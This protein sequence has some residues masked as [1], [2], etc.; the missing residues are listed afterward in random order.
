E[1]LQDDIFAR[2]LTFPN[3]L[4]T[5]HQAFFTR[6]ALEGIARTTQESLD[7]FRTGSN[8]KYQILPPS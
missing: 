5:A 6:D 8:L 7:A 4:I 2:L 3:V 1:V